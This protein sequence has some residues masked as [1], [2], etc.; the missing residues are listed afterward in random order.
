MEERGGAVGRTSHLH[1]HGAEE[2]ECNE[3]TF[4]PV[5]Q[6]QEAAEREE[7][8]AQPP[9]QALTSEEQDPEPVE[10]K[11]LHVCVRAGFSCGGR[12][13]SW[14]GGE[15]ERWREWGVGVRERERER[16]REREREREREL[17]SEWERIRVGVS[18]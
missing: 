10:T 3:K 2:L 16:V 15:V 12:R 13:G 4:C 11:V 7:D 18:V 1:G 14:S 8:E 6:V 9:Y 5:C 17:E